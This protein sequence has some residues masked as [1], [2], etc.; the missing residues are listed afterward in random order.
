[1]SEPQYQDAIKN[2]QKV[3]VEKL[4]YM[5]SWSWHDDP[6]RLAFVLSRYKFVA[7]MLEGANSVLEV[8]CGDGFASRVVRQT[9]GS[10]TGIDFDPAFIKNARE[11]VSKKWP[12][13][14]EEHDILAKPYAKKFDG[15]YCLDVMEHILPEK[16]NL[17]IEHLLC[18]L[19]ETGALIVGMPSIQSQVY[20]N[21]QSKAGHVNCKDHAVLKNTFKKYFHQVFLF[22]MNDEVIHTGFGPMAHYLIVICCLPK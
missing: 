4:G 13:V 19:K 11:N 9:V 20:G 21:E 8:G 2:I 10:L 7:K 3:G 22:S 1:M 6:R 17:F 12:I 5:S 16:E 15:I 14:F 18:S